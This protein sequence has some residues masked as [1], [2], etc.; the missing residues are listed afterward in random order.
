MASNTGAWVAGAY[1]SVTSAV[2]DF[3]HVDNDFYLT[4][5]QLELNS[6]SDFE[7]EDYGTTYNKCLRYF[8]YQP[9]VVNT[10][11][12]IGFSNTTT[13]HQCTL[14]FTEKRVSNPT[15]AV[16][17]ASQWEVNRQ[18]TDQTCTALAGSSASRVGMTFIGI[19]SSGL[20]VGEAAAI[21]SNNSGNYVTISSEL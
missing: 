15:I 21:R 20:T 10:F 6:A 7:H 2:N 5:V 3:D 9:Y 13:S 17:T 4:G 16:S 19:V 11:V 18:G 1:L 12:A 8:E 14:Q